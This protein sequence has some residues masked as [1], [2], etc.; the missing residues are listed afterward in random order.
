MTSI[1]RSTSSRLT[2]ASA[3]VVNSVGSMPGRS[4]SSRRTAMPTSSKAAH[5]GAQIFRLFDDQPRNFR[6]DHATAE[7]SHSKRCQR[8]DVQKSGR[9]L[10]K[11]TETSFAQRG[12]DPESWRFHSSLYFLR[13]CSR[14]TLWTR[15]LRR[16]SQTKRASAHALL[17]CSLSLCRDRLGEAAA[18]SPT[19]SHP[20]SN[21]SKSSIV[22][23][24]IS[25]VI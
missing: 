12:H 2:N 23:R 24:R 14:I 6:S 15:L 8:R 21:A 5:P 17:Y 16:R 4:R 7:Q 25:V 9:T 19:T 1:T 11:V 3:S 22:S 20:A 18:V 10:V 13:L